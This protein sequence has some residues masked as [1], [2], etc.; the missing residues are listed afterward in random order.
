MAGV[1]IKIYVTTVQATAIA[2]YLDINNVF[3]F[4]HFLAI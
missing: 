2:K 1:L 4:S 3:N